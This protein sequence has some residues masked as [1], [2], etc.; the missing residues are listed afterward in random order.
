[1]K[2]RA[3]ILVVD[4]EEKNLLIIKDLLRLSNYEVMLAHDGKEALHKVKTAPPDVI[5]LDTK[6]PG[7]MG[8]KWPAD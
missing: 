3:K 8:L 1:M 4:D 2:K 5:L 7:M 6:M